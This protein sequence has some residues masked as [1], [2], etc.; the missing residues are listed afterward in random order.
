[1]VRDIELS[2]QLFVKRV[3]ETR[4]SIKRERGRKRMNR[5]ERG[6]GERRRR[7]GGE[8]RRGRVGRTRRG[9]RRA[10]RGRRRSGRRRR[11]RRRVRWKEDGTRIE[12]TRRRSDTREV[13]EGRE[14]GEEV[15]CMNGVR[16]KIDS[17]EGRRTRRAVEEVVDGMRGRS[18]F[19]TSV[20]GGAPDEDVEGFQAA[21]EARTKLIERRL[22]MARERRIRRMDGRWTGEED[23][24][25]LDV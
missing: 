12:R 15:G 4:R 9:T 11:R 5:A 24:I 14:R 16:P 18:A 1:M 20:I 3:D 8:K 23:A 25:R 19:R 22:P 7:G 2:N 10:V 13:R 17:K 6:G 21:T